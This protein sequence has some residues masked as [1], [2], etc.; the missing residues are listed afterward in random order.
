MKNS[1]SHKVFKIEIVTYYSSRFLNSKKKKKSKYCNTLMEERYIKNHIYIYTYI[2]V[3]IKNKN[4]KI[5]LLKGKD[6][7]IH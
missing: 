1:L 3:C 6:V 7:E 5:L 2:Y 4:K